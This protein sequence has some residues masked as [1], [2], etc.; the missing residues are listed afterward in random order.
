[1]LGQ[2]PPTPAPLP[3]GHTP[4]ALTCVQPAQVRQPGGARL[5]RPA[6]CQLGAEAGA[7]GVVRL[8]QGGR[9]LALG[10]RV[11]QAVVGPEA[12]GPAAGRGAAG[13][14]RRRPTNL[15]EVR[16]G[17]GPAAV[18]LG[19]AVGAVELVREVPPVRVGGEAEG[20]HRARPRRHAVR[21]G[22]GPAPGLVEVDPVAGV[23][24]GVELAAADEVLLCLEL[25]PT[26]CWPSAAAFL[27]PAGACA[28]G[29]A[30]H[31]PHHG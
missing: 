4:H 12:G 18:G 10:L 11:S 28:G 8:R 13:P 14:A 2:R 17:T 9:A 22:P 16:R 19:A 20:E 23:V 5:V 30:L 1:V 26:G 7:G 29:S 15:Q 24:D 6:P 3:P 25:Q 21:P 27:W 31:H